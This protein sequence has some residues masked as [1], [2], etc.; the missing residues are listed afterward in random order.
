MKNIFRIAGILTGILLIFF[1]QY[2]NYAVF[3]MGIG[4]VL[5]C[6]LKEGISSD[7]LTELSQRWNV[8]TFTT[9]HHNTGFFSEKIDFKFLNVNPNDPIMIYLTRAERH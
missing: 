7:E 4:P 2:A 8:T 1:L 3:P 6:G 5:D 9:V